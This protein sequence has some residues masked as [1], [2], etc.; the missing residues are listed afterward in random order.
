[1]SLL[2][3]EQLRFPPATRRLRLG[4]VGGGRGALVGQ[5]HAAGARLSN[6]W[7]VVA[8]ALSSDPATAVASGADWLI[9]GDRIYTD[10]A[11]MAERESKRPDGIEAVVIV[12]PNHSHKAIAARFLENGIDVI[13]D[14]PLTTTVEDALALVQLQR[15]TGLVFG[16]TYCYASHAMIRQAR[17]MVRAG[18]LGRVRHIHVEYMQEWATTPDDVTQKALTWRR[19]PAKVGRASATNDIGTHAHH[20]AGFVSGLTMTRVRAEFH[21]CGAPKAMED[22]AFMHVRYEDE[23]PGTLWVTQ[24]APGNHCA[25]R[26]RVYGEKAGLEWDQEYPELLRFT[27]LGRPAQAITKGYGSGMLPEAERLVRLSRG[28]PEALTDAWA[29]LYLEL[30]VA[31]EARRAGRPLPEGLLDYPDVAAGARGVRFVHAA[32]ES[33]EAGGAWTSCE[34]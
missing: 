9:A 15:R 7:E 29:N 21:V 16:V 17:A 1:M 20:I 24:A 12:T 26:L 27:P 14:K 34:L 11:E 19:D 18:E 31:V 8:G 32:A 10:W 22:T 33:H 30:A 3:D 25:L 23:V 13:C 28:H 6:R 5:A 2:A 4:F